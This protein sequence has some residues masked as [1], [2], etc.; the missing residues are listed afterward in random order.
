MSY[1]WESYTRKK[2]KIKVE[3][4]LSNYAKKSDLK[5]AT[6]VDTSKFAKKI[7]LANLKLDIEKLD[8]GKL[9]TTPTDSSKLINAVERDFVKKTVYDELVK[10]SNAIQTTDTRDLVKENWL[11]H[12]NW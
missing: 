7:D 9:E 4:D 10:K 5:N 11:Q 3:L 2:N 6:G 12:K 8:I 1:F